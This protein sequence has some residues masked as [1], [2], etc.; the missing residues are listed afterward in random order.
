MRITTFLYF[1]RGLWGE[2]FCPSDK[3]VDAVFSKL[4]FTYP[5]KSFRGNCDRYYLVAY[6]YSVFERKHF[7]I[8]VKTFSSL[9][10]TASYIYRRQLVFFFVFLWNMEISDFER[11]SYGMIGKG[12]FLPVQKVVGEK[13]FWRNFFF[14]FFCALWSKHFHTSDKNV[15]AVFLNMHCTCPRQ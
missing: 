2:N 5:E 4:R 3:I 12:F 6:F 15:P 8:W 9:L 14:L 10:K 7:V 11:Y 1:F 13:F